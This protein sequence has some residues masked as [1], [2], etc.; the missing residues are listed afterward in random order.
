MN[1][2][3][4]RHIPISDSGKIIGLLSIGDIISAFALL[5]ESNFQNKLLKRYIESWPTEE[6]G[7]HPVPGSQ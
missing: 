5:E 2:N 7:Q 6:E 4:I 3:R 1:R